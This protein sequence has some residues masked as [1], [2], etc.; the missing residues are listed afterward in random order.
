VVEAEQ[1]LF[2]HTEPEQVE[3]VVIEKVKMH[4]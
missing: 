3:Q 4:Q 2:Q 1:E